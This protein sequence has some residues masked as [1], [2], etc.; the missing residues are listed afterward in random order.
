MNDTSEALRLVERARALHVLSCLMQLPVVARSQVDVATYQKLGGLEAEAFLDAVERGLPH[1]LLAEWEERRSTNSRYAPGLRDRQ[2][3]RLAVLLSVALQ[4]AGLG[5]GKREA[6]K[7]TAKALGHLFRIASHRAIEHWELEL[8]PPLSPED[9]AVIKAASER[10]GPNPDALI[11]HFVG[12]VRFP[13]AVVDSRL[14]PSVT[15]DE[16]MIENCK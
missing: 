7:R 15:G 16:N 2:F 13:L 1:P 5:M 4:K 3:R 6:R 8:D 12:F 14:P 11:K 9:E 10:C